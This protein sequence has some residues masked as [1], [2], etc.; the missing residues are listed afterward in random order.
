MKR[1]FIPILIVVLAFFI[2][3]SE[4]NILDIEDD[5]DVVSDQ[6]L[7]EQLETADA[8]IPQWRRMPHNDITLQVPENLVYEP[9][10]HVVN[11][12][13]PATKDQSLVLNPRFVM[14]ANRIYLSDMSG[15]NIHVFDF[16]GVMIEGKKMS[17]PSLSVKPPKNDNPRFF[18]STRDE[19]NGLIISDDGDMISQRTNG[20][21]LVTRFIQRD[22]EYQLK[23]FRPVRD[24]DITPVFYMDNQMW[25]LERGLHNHLPDFILYGYEIPTGFRGRT[26]RLETD[27][28]IRSFFVTPH[29]FVTEKHIYISYWLEEN[30]ED[31]KVWTRNGKYVKNIDIFRDVVHLRGV[32]HSTFFYHHQSK[33][34]YVLDGL[35][36]QSREHKYI[37]LALQQE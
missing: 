12:D 24:G 19:S 20:V 5:N 11:L 27:D 30:G 31:F 1:L 33:T 22:G 2:G 36:L 14:S 16:N 8:T 17:R 21:N 26:I 9:V 4:S 6:G 28:V 15:M 10:R 32:S 18:R 13:E 7:S 23:E 34:L 35:A 3:C 37:L 25:T 29:A